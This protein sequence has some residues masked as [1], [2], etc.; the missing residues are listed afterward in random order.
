MRTSWLKILLMAAA[1]CLTASVSQAAVDH[2]HHQHPDSPFGG[3]Q[4]VKHLHCVLKGHS[5]DKPC[6]HIM[7][8]QRGNS[9]QSVIANECGGTPL[10][11]NSHRIGSDNIFPIDAMMFDGSV[12]SSSNDF[13]AV[14]SFYHRLAFHSLEPPPKSL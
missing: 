6:P 8:R 2:S 13:S 1:F 11:S 4:I 9:G 12:E 7:A 10:P 14:V 5:M 3:E